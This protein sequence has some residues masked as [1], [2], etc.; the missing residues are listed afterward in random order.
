MGAGFVQILAGQTDYFSSAAAI[1]T[2]LQFGWEPEADMSPVSI[3]Q[4]SGMQDDTIPYDGGETPVG[5]FYSAEESARIWAAH[6]SCDEKPVIT[7]TQEGNRKIVYSG[8]LNGTQVVHYGITD[9]GHG[10]P[11]ETEGGLFDLVWS[12][13]RESASGVEE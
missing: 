12:F 9:G 1:V 2:Q 8:C 4:I 6:N 7:S 5:D 13:L 10:L 11:A 3:L